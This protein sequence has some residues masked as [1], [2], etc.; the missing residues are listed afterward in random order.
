LQGL[1]VAVAAAQD[2]G[3]PLVGVTVRQGL[4]AQVGAH[5]QEGLPLQRL[6]IYLDRTRPAEDLGGKPLGARRDPH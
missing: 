3:V 1:P 5:T 4:M 2:L 6:T